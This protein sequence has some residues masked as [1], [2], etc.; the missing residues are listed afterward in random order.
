MIFHDGRIIMTVLPERPKKR[1]LLAFAEIK[2]GDYLT[3]DKNQ[4]CP[5]SEII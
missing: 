2:K 4:I 1:V 3:S 5:Q